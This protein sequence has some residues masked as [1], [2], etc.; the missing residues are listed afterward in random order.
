MPGKAGAQNSQSPT[1][2][3]VAGNLGTRSRLKRVV[4][5]LADLM[6]ADLSFFRLS[7][8]RHKDNHV[9]IAVQPMATNGDQ[10]RWSSRKRAPICEKRRSIDDR[11][12]RYRGLGSRVADRQT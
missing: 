2:G 12:S 3:I 8:T 10:E 1:P 11:I 5:F 6:A 9:G 4:C 7:E